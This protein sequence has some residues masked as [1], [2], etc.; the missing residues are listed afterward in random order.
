MVSCE[1]EMKSK[2][3]YCLWC[4]EEIPCGCAL[5][6]VRDCQEKINDLKKTIA[7][8]SNG[9]VDARVLHSM[10]QTIET[11]QKGCEVL[12]NDIQGQVKDIEYRLS[13][14]VELPTELDIR[15][16]DVERIVDKLGDS[17]KEL[18]ELYQSDARNMKQ[19]LSELAK[20]NK[21]LTKIERHFSGDYQ[22]IASK[23]NP[24]K[25]PA[26]DGE[27]FRLETDKL[28]EHECVSCEGKGIVWG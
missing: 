24:H 14:I 3:D 4:K 12:I 11:W 9:T 10:R 2:V 26:C 28:A 27:G 6:M 23:L 8:I 13:H 16:Q 22:L 19:I 1:K 15:L 5:A 17:S 25:C 7:A 18:K 20:D 21:R